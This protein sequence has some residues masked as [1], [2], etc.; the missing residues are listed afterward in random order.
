MGPENTTDM[1]WWTAILADLLEVF[2][3]LLEVFFVLLEAFCS[4]EQSFDVFK[5]ITWQLQQ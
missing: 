3:V 5:D 4:I 2:F 1:T